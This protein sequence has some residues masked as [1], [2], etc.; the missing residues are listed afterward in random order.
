MQ[1]PIAAPKALAPVRRRRG[2]PGETVAAWSFLTP[3]LVGFVVFVVGPVVASFVLSFTQYDLIRPPKFIGLDNYATLLFHDPLMWQSLGNTLYYSVLTIPS[4]I[5]I[6]LALALALNQG[7]R[8]TIVYRTLYFLP[9]V[10][11]AIA[12]SFVWKWLYNPD[13]GLLNWLLSL[14]NITG[15]DWLNDPAWAMPSIAAA[16][17]WKSLGYTMVIL[18]AGLQGVPQHLYEAAKIDGASA[19]E[20]FRHVTLPLISPSLFFV[21]VISVI[22]SFQVF[23]QVYVMTQGGPGHATL[24]YNYYLYQNAFQYF[25]MGYASAMAY[26]LFAIILVATLIQVRLLNRRV[27]YDVA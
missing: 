3:N 6:A 12:I 7:L 15:P 4:G 21:T 9:V 5:V 23:D 2:L 20:R 26:I 14:V 8:G 18:L 17:V 19:W 16:A 25:K 11:S 22:G 13:F 27:V 24:V 10:T 1:Q